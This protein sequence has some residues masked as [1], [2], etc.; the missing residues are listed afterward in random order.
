MK[1]QRTTI[2]KELKQEI[3]NYAKINNYLLDI[4]NE[5]SL[6]Q[7][8]VKKILKNNGI[9][10][11]NSYDKEKEL[12]LYVLD[13]YL[14]S[15]MT[16][17]EIKKKNNISH[18]KFLRILRSDNVVSKS[19]QKISEAYRNPKL[20][21]EMFTIGKKT[22]PEIV[23]ITQI[24]RNHIQKI[25]KQNN[26]DTLKATSK[27]LE[28]QVLE[29]YCI[30]NLSGMQIS[31]LLNISHTVVYKILKKHDIVQK[32]RSQIM[33]K[34]NNEDYD[35]YIQNL[36]EF[37]KYRIKVNSITD[38]QPLH[39]LE[40]YKKRGKTG[41][42]GAHHVDHKF[43]VME[44]FKNNIPADIISHICNLQMIPWEENLSKRDRCSITIQDLIN[45]I[46]Q[47]EN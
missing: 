23:S 8:T 32:S 6:H 14:N 17:K 30:K 31:E 25:F 40:N 38:K 35:K 11:V 33:T 28:T 42:S 22:I 20:I 5:F 21:I 36:P 7:T 9:Q 15:N 3:V 26:I 24:P 47:H 29:L 34:L 39:T 27:K 44:G 43:S 41:I 16:D 4:V 12:S 18:D 10:Y 19:K 45:K 37:V 13:L 46:K 2:T 1:K